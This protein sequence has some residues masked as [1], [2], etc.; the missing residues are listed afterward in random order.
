MVFLT[1]VIGVLNL[2]LGYALAV[3]LSCGP[4]SLREA[5]YALSGTP[6]ADDV[7]VAPE[8]SVLDTWKLVLGREMSAI[9]VLGD[10][11]RKCEQQPDH[12]MIRTCAAEFQELCQASLEEHTQAAERFDD[13][14]GESDELGPA[15]EE[16]QNTIY[17]QLAQLETTI[18]NLRRLDL[19]FDLP[20]TAKHL[21]DEIDRLSTVGHKLQNGLDTAFSPSPGMKPD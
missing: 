1:F 11:L 9:A 8:L 14:F 6:P 19:E 13:H 18:G 2:A 20:G 16:V 15:G 5:W 10:R 21:M 4:P 7:Q 12:E 17:E 3:H